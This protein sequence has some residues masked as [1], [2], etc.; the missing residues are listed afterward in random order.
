M[1][2][3]KKKNKVKKTKNKDS[4]LIEGMRAVSPMETT[5]SPHLSIKEKVSLD[6]RC[7]IH[8]EVSPEFRVAFKVY[9][10]ERKMTMLELFEKCFAFYKKVH[11]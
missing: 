8:L 10:F 3:T 2:K 11:S 7:G 5:L 6:P 1:A 9:A 4:L